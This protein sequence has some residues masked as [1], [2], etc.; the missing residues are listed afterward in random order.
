MVLG[1]V[2]RVFLRNGLCIAH[3]AEY[4]SFD[5]GVGGLRGGGSSALIVLADGF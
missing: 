5:G 4:P 1:K 3:V 2:L